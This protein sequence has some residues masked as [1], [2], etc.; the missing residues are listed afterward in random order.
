[1]PT[2]YFVAWWNLENLFD[3]QH[4]ART[5]KLQRAIG[6]DLDGW[7]P[8][9][10]D[11]KIDQLASVIASLNGNQGPDL[12]G[13]CEVEN[14]FVVNRLR[15]RLHDRLPGRSYDVVHADTD[16]Q[17]G[18]DIAFIY[19]DTMLTAPPD[20][21]FQH[22]VMRR[23]ATRAVLQ[24]NF[25]TVSAGRTWTVFGNHWP[26]R[27]GGEYES[28][29][30]RAIAGETLSYFHERAREVHSDHTPVIVMGDFNDQP[31]DVSLTRHA[32]STSQRAKV[33]NAT[34]RPL[35]WNLMWP[36]MGRARATFYWQNIANMLDQFLVN[37][38]MIVQSAPIRVRADTLLI[39]DGFPGLAN[40]NSDYPKAVPFGGMGKPVNQ[41]G[42]SDH[43]PI[44]IRVTEA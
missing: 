34:T 3:H 15:D 20:E 17:R 27:S 30:Y 33:L 13:I 10:R 1:M 41:N 7:T 39:E 18:I 14:E 12:L 26:S 19:E 9:L 32:L 43:L 44:S 29:G 6:R 11:R 38:N 4:A 5:D 2:D 21:V 16:D 23:T 31:S 35:L 24:V 42:Y 36:E 25:Q 28:A 37:R 22:V 40:L 8:Q